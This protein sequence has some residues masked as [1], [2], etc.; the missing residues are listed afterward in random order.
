MLAKEDRSL[1]TLFSDLTQETTALL[2]KEVELAKVEISEKVSQAQSG[3]VSLATG[4]AVLY[5]GLLFLLLALVYGISAATNWDLWV[6]ALIVGAVVSIIGYA[7]LARGRRNLKA[8]NLTLP[9]TVRSLRRD[10][11]LAKEQV[12]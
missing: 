7:L 1:A 3:A 9:R 12:Q 6:S 11:E 2:R 4:G 10:K 5:A 8:E